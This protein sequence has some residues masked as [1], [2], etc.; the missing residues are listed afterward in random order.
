MPS[1]PQS[2]LWI[3]L[4]VLWLFVL[5]PMFIVLWRTNSFRDLRV[6]S[7]KA[8]LFRSVF[9]VAAAICFVTSVSVLPLADVHAI[10]FAGPIFIAALSPLLVAALFWRGS[11]R[12]GALA[13]TLWVAASVTA[14]A[15]FQ[16]LVPAPAPGPPIVVWRAFGLEALSRT[17]GGTAVFG[18]MPVVPMVLVSA[19]L[20][21]V[22]SLATAKPSQ[23]TVDKYFPEREPRA[24]A[25]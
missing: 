10:G 19:L 17:P 5:V 4:V 13:S 21:Y 18:F 25:A 2:L 15:V 12:W 20:M 24:Q 1:I 22:V 6:H 7:W 16:A 23:A 8:Q 9:H 3:S 14:V 11:T